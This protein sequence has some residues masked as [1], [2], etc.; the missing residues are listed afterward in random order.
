MIKSYFQ[1][2]FRHLLKNKT[3]SIINI[4]GLAI[5]LACSFLIFLHVH[6][7]L[8]YDDHFKD[9]E[10]IHRLAVKASMSGNEFEAAVTGGPFAYLLHQEIPEVIGYTRIR[11]GRMTLLSAGEKSFY[12]ENILYADSSFFE[13]FSFE[14]DQGDPLTSLVHPNCMVLTEKMAKK[15][16]GNE[17]PVGKQIK[18]N[19]DQNYTITGI[20][21]DPEK[22]SHLNFDILVSFCT[23][24]QNERWRNFLSSIFNY[25]TLNYIKLHPGSD[26]PEVESK[27]AEVVDK[28]MAERL[29]QIEGTYEVYLQPITSIYLHSNILHEMRENGD[30]SRVYIFAAVAI[31]ILII[32]C[33]NF[34]NLSTARSAKRSTE[35]GLRKVFGAN[36]GMLFKQFILESVIIVIISLIIAVILFDLMLPLLNNLTG[37][38]FTMSLF[39]NWRYLIFLFGIVLF[40]GLLAGSYPAIYMSRFKPITV[41]KGFVF[42]NSKKAGFRNVMVITQFII[43][44]FLIAGTLLIY[45]QLNY[46]NNKDL[47]IDNKNLVVVSLRNSAMTKNYMSL[48]AEMKNLPGVIDVTGSSSYLGNF[49]Q[50]RG[51]YPEGGD[52]DDM[53]LMLHMQADPNYLD[54]FDANISTGR[55]FFENSIADSNAI[56]INKAYQKE[57]GWDDPV[58]KLI[59]IPGGV[60]GEEGFPLKI[61][62]VVEDFNFASLHEEV[63][64]L[65]IMNQPERINYLSIKINPEDKKQVL[66]LISAKWESLYPEYPFEYFMQQTKYEEMYTSEVNM[67]RLFVY[68][69]FLAIF[70]AALGLFGLSSFTTEQRTR[71]IGIRKVL[72]SSI[73]EI[74]ILLSKE[75]SRLVIIAIVIAIPISWFGM[76]KW[77]QSFAFQ[78][79]ISWWIFVV[80]GILAILIAYLTIIFQAIKA[81]RTSPVDALK[82]E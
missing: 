72:G 33:I 52:I 2:A 31:L 28:N 71:E 58:G 42:N 20:V 44:I 64:P 51:F 4:I 54:V 1:L 67:S 23:L 61:V 29:A 25:S 12:E 11:E 7:E 16:F 6:T 68:F 82:Y 50:R 77:L 36:K 57:L 53:I 41:L 8:S 66:G 63:M 74:L 32:A 47:G 78:T 30:A 9:A 45:R 69:T 3:F 35:V 39:M 24:Y 46:I 17:D 43:S 21:K 75:F 55:N 48:K 27:I 22:K 18:W 40:V 38:N 80:S 81:S 10:N 14:L 60:E 5:G 37:N 19:N 13:I 49:Q 73:S 70:I 59:Y 76:D 65:I 56:I 79:N 26:I 34:I 15:F 62:G